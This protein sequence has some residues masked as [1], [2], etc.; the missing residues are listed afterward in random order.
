MQATS[1]LRFVCTSGGLKV[2]S[3]VKSDFLAESRGFRYVL[4]DFLWS[5]VSTKLRRFVRLFDKLVSRLV[6][7]ELTFKCFCLVYIWD[8]VSVVFCFTFVMLLDGVI[9][10]F[11]IL[12]EVRGA[13]Q[14]L[15]SL[16]ELKLCMLSE[17]FVVFKVFT[18]TKL[19]LYTGLTLNRGLEVA[20]ILEIVLERIR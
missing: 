16:S 14:L 8:F 12:F 18:L 2:G 5:S 3:A 15:G 10:A 20:D 4:G 1:W 7:L 9:F 11:L 6:L 13:G 17:V 19:P